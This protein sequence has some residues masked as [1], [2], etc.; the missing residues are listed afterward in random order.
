MLSIEKGLISSGFRKAHPWIGSDIKILGSRTQGHFDITMCVPQISR[1]VPDIDSYFQNVVV[2]RRNV[3]KTLKS[4][5][6]Y[7]YSLHINTRDNRERSELY[8]TAIGSSLESGD[9]GLVGRGN[10]I[11]GFIAPMRPMSM[12]G[13]SGKNPVYHIGKLYYAAAQVISDRIQKRFGIENEVY[14]VSQSGRDLLDP[15]LIM[16]RVSESFSNVDELK[17]LI[18]MEVK[19]IPKLTKD[20][21]AEKIRLC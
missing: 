14:L 6:I 7:D 4:I 21:L 15:W 8:L 13:G 18:I 3:E 11:Q 10:R 12:E 2:I 5:G 20:I 16:V 1:Y 19:S 9:E 17:K